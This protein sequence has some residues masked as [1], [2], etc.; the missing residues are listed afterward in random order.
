MLPNVNERFA[1][2]RL[3]PS[4]EGERV[5]PHIPDKIRYVNYS[6]PISPPSPAQPECQRMRS[7]VSVMA[8]L[9]CQEMRNDAVSSSLARPCQLVRVSHDQRSVLTSVATGR[10]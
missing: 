6:F 2:A 1:S 8:Q 3:Q 5:P 7:L 10:R 4:E 9:G